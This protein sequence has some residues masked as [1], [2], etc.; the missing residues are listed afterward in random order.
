MLVDDMAGPQSL[1]GAELRRWLE[2][3]GFSAFQ[4]DQGLA[5]TCQG[6]SS[7]PWQVGTSTSSLLARVWMAYLTCQ[8]AL[9]LGSLGAVLRSDRARRSVYFDCLVILLFGPMQVNIA[10]PWV[11]SLFFVHAIERS[12]RNEWGELAAA[13]FAPQR[14]A[15]EGPGCFGSGS[16]SPT[17]FRAESRGREPDS[18]GNGSLE[19]KERRDE[20]L[21]G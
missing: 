4:C 13:A 2:K 18:C 14:D 15:A 12:Q 17:A 10:V 1:V 8:T 9:R 3:T 20:Q 21:G 6:M 5:M 19:M 16:G 7:K 11:L